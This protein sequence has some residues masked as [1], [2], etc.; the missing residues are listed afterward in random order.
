MRCCSLMGLA[1]V[2]LALVHTTILFWGGDRSTGMVFGPERTGADRLPIE[3]IESHEKVSLYVLVL[4]PLTGLI[5]FREIFVMSKC[6]DAVD[7]EAVLLTVMQ[8]VR[9]KVSLNFTYIASYQFLPLQAHSN[10]SSLSNDSES[11]GLICK[12]G[13]TECLGNRQQLWYPPPHHPRC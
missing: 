12:H 9:S 7:A 13:H 6:P 10:L 4:C 8:N 2:L 11:R 1:V 5:G 3:S